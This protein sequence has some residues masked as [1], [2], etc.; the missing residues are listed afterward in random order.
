M[1]FAP[2]GTSALKALIKSRNSSQ[3][4]FPL[5]LPCAVST[6]FPPFR[7]WA[8]W[9]LTR[10]NFIS[11][12]SLRPLIFPFLLLLSCRECRLA[13]LR[14]DRRQMAGHQIEFYLLRAVEHG[15]IV[16]VSF[17]LCVAFFPS[18][19]A[20]IYTVQDFSKTGKRL[21]RCVR[22]RSLHPQ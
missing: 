14:P 7:C 20:A 13:A 2:I 19:S 22:M 11:T 15:Q 4:L 9:F 10:N 16:A 8:I 12:P 6:S 5:H 21:D 17:H 18:S 3:R 1:P